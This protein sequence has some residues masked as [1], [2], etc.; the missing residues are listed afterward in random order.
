MRHR[1]GTFHTPTLL[2]DQAPLET[3]KGEPSEAVCSLF[4]GAALHATSQGNTSEDEHDSDS[5]MRLGIFSN[6][7]RYLEYS[8]TRGCARE[9]V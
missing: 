3:G 5:W 6:Q 1:V 7:C 4:H 2:G 8:Q 9:V